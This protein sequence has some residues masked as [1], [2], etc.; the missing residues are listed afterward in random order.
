M[1]PTRAI[2]GSVEC[3]ARRSGGD[4][5]QAR[6]RKRR[7]HRDAVEEVQELEEAQRARAELHSRIDR[8]ETERQDLQRELGTRGDELA[9]ARN[10][11]AADLQR[12]RDAQAA[13]EAGLSLRSAELSNYAPM[14]SP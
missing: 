12:A 4:D 3:Q 11:N 7:R 6:C 9:A 13:A 1:R 2:G 14:P 10:A 5:L 8:L